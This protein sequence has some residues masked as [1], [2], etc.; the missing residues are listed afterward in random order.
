M[1][2][3]EA[4]SLERK[5]QLLSSAR[6]H[7]NLYSQG[8]D[9][10]SF[11]RIYLESLRRILAKMDKDERA[12]FVSEL[13][14]SDSKLET[15]VDCL[16]APKSRSDME[17]NEALVTIIVPC[18]NCE[19]Y[20]LATIKS[21]LAQTYRN[22][23][24]IL[25]D[26]F[27]VDG[28]P[29]IAKDMTARDKR[30]RFFQHRANGGLAASRNTGIRLSKG[31]YVCFLDSDD[32]LAADSLKNRVHAIE[33]YSSERVVA[34]VFDF[35]ETIPDDYS[36]EIQ[37]RKTKYVEDYVDFISSKGDC[38][39][40]ANQ[41]L[42]KR[43]VLLEMGGFPE[44]YPQAE[45]WRLWAKIFRSGYLF[46]PVRTIGSGYRQTQGSMIR[47]APLLH[48]EKSSGNFYRAHNTYESEEAPLEVRYES[49]FMASSYF[50]RENGFYTAQRSFIPRLFNFIGIDLA[51]LSESD[52]EL[53]LSNLKS[54]I[55]KA[56]PDFDSVV[57]GYTYPNMR[58]WMENGY[59]RFFGV[60]QLSPQR[61]EAFNKAAHLV[62]K[63]TFKNTDLFVVGEAKKA[64]PR[65]NLTRKEH[66]IVDV[67][68]F[69]HKAYHTKSFELLLPLLKEKGLSFKFVDISV[70]YRDEQAYDSAL[71]GHFIS[72]NEFVLSRILPRSI[73][74]MNDW[75]T[76]VRPV[77]KAAN[78]CAIPTVGIVEGV[79]DFWDVDTGRKRN[80][81]REVNNVLLPG[82]F[83]KKYFSE[84]EQKLWVSGV[85]PLDGL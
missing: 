20:L 10:E 1:D 41:P 58:S 54:V 62:L 5:G 68:F 22:F 79:Q 28:T 69:P 61:Q 6:I 46:L 56:V 84:S 42:L 78:S 47:R 12:S 75:D 4:N 37:D 11:R 32:L 52:E 65:R 51:R 24:C 43:R 60:H 34:G 63:D 57:A 76:V 74:C 66:D 70:P 82:E 27:S 21:I 14:F 72:Y 31:K 3:S 71:D 35:S 33:K 77:V 7:F 64:I 83:D 18:Y 23:E 45:D 59:K 39:F 40:N 85:Q 67:L 55:L 44:N 9:G 13:L 49:L 19:K 73:V 48:L 29:K 36:G 50:G 8:A 53:N 81:Y 26:D 38:P 16:L 30:F 25:I 17:S 15:I 2:L 80:P